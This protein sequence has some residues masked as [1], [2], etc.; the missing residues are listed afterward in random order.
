[1]VKTGIARRD[2][3]P[4][5]SVPL[6]GYGDRTHD[7]TGIH[8][9]LSVYA[10]WIE[11]EGEAPFAWVVLDLC[12]MG[13]GAARQLASEAAAQAAAPGLTGER[14]LVSTTHTHSGP[15]TLGIESDDRPWAKRYYRLLVE[16]TAQAIVEAREGARACTIEVREA[17]GSLGVNRR[18]PRMPVDP[19]IILLS[20]VDAEG[21]LQGVLFHYSCHLTV[22]GVDNYLVS[23][24]WAGPVRRSLEAEL[25]VPVA[26]LQGAEGNIDPITRGFLDMS[27]PDQARGSSFEVLSELAGEVLAALRAGLRS[28][29]VVRLGRAQQLAWE[30]EVPLRD[31]APSPEGVRARIE[32]W[33]SEFAEFLGIPAAEVPEGRIVNAL[34]KERCRALGLPREEI[35]R[36]VASQFAYG[37]FLL[38]YGGGREAVQPRQGTARLPCRI[39]D[40]GGLCVLG[41]PLE[42]LVEAAFDWQRRLTGRIALV[43]GLIGGWLGY[44]PHRS[45]FEEAEAGQLYETVSTVFAPSACE[46]ML[47]EAQRRATG[48]KA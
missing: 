11:G 10:W 22:L 25:G 15:D 3:T 24:D 6:F 38:T 21:R 19:R 23:A 30:Q 14:L 48:G 17:A 39:I 1:M 13:I 12:L 35:R 16:R 2:I 26:Y 45:N 32:Q 42:I 41:A 29:P 4:Q 28:A 44:M 34:V 31:G 47:D 8:D 7:S 18:D 40:F 27:D 33:K 37:S 5:E 46:K 20:L 9:P 43:S 36:R